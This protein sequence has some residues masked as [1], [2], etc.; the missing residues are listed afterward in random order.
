ML[1]KY[2]T[3]EEILNLKESNDLMYKSLEVVTH[4]F[5]DK[6]D[7]GGLPYSVHL[8]KVY[9][10]VNDYTEKVCALLHDTVEDTDITFDDLKELGFNDEIIDILKVLTKKKGE[11]Y[12]VYID[13][14]INS[15]N[16]HAM[17]IKLADLRHNMD[18][19]RIKNPT[20]NDYER[21]SKR[22]QPAYD[23]ILNKLGEMEK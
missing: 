20:S 8:L 10:G 21:V 14:I 2:F 13:R 6:C 4:L 11:D 22:Y 23:R 16:T 3:E 1:E 7:K 5:D 9:L 19:T 15:N 18:I 12:R 17:N